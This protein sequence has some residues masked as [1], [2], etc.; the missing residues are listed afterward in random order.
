M[1]KLFFFF[2]ILA[3]G[4]GDGPDGNTQTSGPWLIDENLI[5]DGGPGKDGI[6]AINDPKFSSLNEV[7]FLSDDDLILGYRSGNI[8]RAYPHPVLDY[9]EIVN[10]DIG[11]ESIALTYCPLTGTGIGWDREYNGNKTTFGV[12]G[13]LYNSN[14]MPYDRLTGSTW[15]QQRLDCVNGER[16]SEKAKLFS[17]IETTWGSWKTAYPNA[18]ILNTD[19][20]VSRD[21]SRYPYGNYKTN[22]SNLIFPITKED[23]RLA[24]KERVLGVIISDSEKAFDFADE[25]GNILIKDQVAGQDISVISNKTL[26][27]IV[28]FNGQDFELLEENEFPYI[29]INSEGTKFDILGFPSDN[30]KQPLIKPTQFVGYWFSWATFYEDIE[31]YQ[32]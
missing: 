19:T 28:A 26:N 22:N 17:F 31:L 4:C 3:V 6:P 5:L 9:H 32:R 14:L 8:I 20:G 23:D 24:L 25:S 1:K 30:S 21:Y 11:N 13:L 16:I 7:N 2:I 27:Y 29:V 10:D 15:S 18:Q 12:S